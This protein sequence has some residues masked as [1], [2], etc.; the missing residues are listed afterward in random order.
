M[1]QLIGRKATE[2]G[3][4]FQAEARTTEKLGFRVLQF[5]VEVE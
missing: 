1:I 3:W 2:N 4:A 5:Q